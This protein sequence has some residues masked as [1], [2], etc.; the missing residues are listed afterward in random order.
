MDING[1][2]FFQITSNGKIDKRDLPSPDF[3]LGG[4]SL[5]PMKLK[6]QIK[7][8]FKVELPLAEVFMTPTIRALTQKL[9]EWKIGEHDEQT[10]I[11]LNSGNTKNQ[12]SFHDP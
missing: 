8:T 9:E 10:L 12:K 7:N 3:S 2:M 4:H 6:Y 5:S 1:W 11:M